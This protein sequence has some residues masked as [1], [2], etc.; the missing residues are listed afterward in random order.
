MR[1]EII[2][3]KLAPGRFRGCPTTTPTP[4]AG[5]KR[6]LNAF[7][8][9]SDAGT[10]VA[11]EPVLIPGRWNGTPLSLSILEEL[12]RTYNP[13]A[14]PAPIKQTHEDKGA[15]LGWVDGLSLQDWVPP[16]QTKPRKAL[17]ARFKVND[18]LRKAKADGYLM[19]SVEL[20]P[21]DHGNSPTR[22]RWHFKGL[23]LLG[24]E[25]PACPNLTPLSFAD[26]DQEIEIPVL[27]LADEGPSPQPGGPRPPL[28]KGDSV[29]T[30]TTPTPADLEAANQRAQEAETRA[31][32]L[33]IRLANQAKEADQAKVI[34]RLDGLVQA[35]K[36]V[37][38]QKASLLPV[39]LALDGKETTISLANG[40]AISPREALFQQLEGLQGHNLDTRA[41]VPGGPSQEQI[42]LASK[43]KNKAFDNKVNEYIKAGKSRREALQMACKEF[44]DEEMEA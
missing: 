1:I 32:D 8:A 36:L 6:A 9:L 38:A 43:A 22:G 44:A 25:S 28:S 14:Q 30:K 39:L 2:S 19:K 35:K 33:E 21:P 13:S 15:A 3:T 41:Q 18:A 31:K 12:V 34:A 11:E 37:P 7:L 27:L 40:T 29:E 17:F 16:G 23:A 24:A 20:W 5:F 42:D 4:S 26:Q 10:Q